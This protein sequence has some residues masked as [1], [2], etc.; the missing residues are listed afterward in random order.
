MIPIEASSAES[1]SYLEYGT[2]QAHAIHGSFSHLN[3]YMSISPSNNAVAKCHIKFMCE[4]H[5][6]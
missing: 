3:W 4:V 6:A 1:T 2:S 5:K